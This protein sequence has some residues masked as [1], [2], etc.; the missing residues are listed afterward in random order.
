MHGTR[1]GNDTRRF[2]RHMLEMTLA[3]MVGMVA[4]AAIFLSAVR[5]TAAEAMREHAVLFVVLQACGMAIAM[6]AWMHHRGHTA[7]SSSEMTLAM[8]IPA[9][10][11][12]CLR[13]LD[14]ISGQICGVY[15]LATIV[16]MFALMFYR[17]SDYGVGTTLMPTHRQP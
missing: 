17:R 12:I 13:M 9:V 6:V 5:M 10:P 4:S 7:R 2:L 1:S 11:L 16:A 15:C 8:V 14:I 3:M